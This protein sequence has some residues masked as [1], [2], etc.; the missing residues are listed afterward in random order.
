VKALVGLV[1]A[2]SACAARVVRRVMSLRRRTAAMARRVLDAGDWLIPART[3]NNGERG[4]EDRATQRAL[5]RRCARARIDC[6]G[7]GLCALLY[8]A[9]LF[10]CCITMAGLSVHPPRA[11]PDACSARC[12]PQPR[13]SRA[14]LRVSPSAPATAAERCC[15]AAAGPHAGRWKRRHR[16]YMCLHRQPRLL[17]LPPPPRD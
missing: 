4:V 10:S 11:S 5:R 7:H 14:S 6:I 15:A 3:T 16:G 9:L 13:R 8:H 2:W 17:H 1:A 12:I